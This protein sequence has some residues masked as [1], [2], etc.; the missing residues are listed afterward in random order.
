MKTTPALNFMMTLYDTMFAG[1]N[2]AYPASYPICFN[3]N[4]AKVDWS[5]L[6]QF[7]SAC[8][9]ASNFVLCMNG[10]FNGYGF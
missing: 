3:N 2:L 6:Q 7:A 10:F 9:V 4:K 5:F 1:L 8:P